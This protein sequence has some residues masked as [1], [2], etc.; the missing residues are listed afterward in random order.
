MRYLPIFTL[1]LFAAG[2]CS[3]CK[4]DASST[5]YHDD[6]RAK[7]VAALPIMI[8]TTAF[9]APWSISEEI[10][11]TIAQIVG[12]NGKIFIQSQDDF[13][14]ASNPFAGDLSWMKREF[15]NQE[16]GIFLELAEH[17][18]VAS[19]KGGSES[20]V[21]NNLNMGVRIRV[22]DL[23]G[24]E[25]KVVLQEMI[26]DSYYIP[27][28]LVPVDYDVVTW[29]TEDYKKSPMGVA[30]AQLAKEI[31]ERVSEYILLAKSR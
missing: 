26:R 9:D 11:A 21:S 15:Q 7:P 4:D 14:I 27:K 13:A 6:G 2:C 16:F 22:V 10:T 24:A 29:G 3:R 5:R 31:A 18:L 20:E 1:V 28:T 17:E 19:N 30:H 23:R 8:D 25:P 12:K